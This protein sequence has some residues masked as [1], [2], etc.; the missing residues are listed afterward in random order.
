MTYRMTIKEAFK[1]PP[2]T[3]VGSVIGAIL[4]I[5]MIGL[6]ALFIPLGWYAC[7]VIGGVLNHYGVF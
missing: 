3:W 7:L 4:C 6:D 2:F 5:P 1:P